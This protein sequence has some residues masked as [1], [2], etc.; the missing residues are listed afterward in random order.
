MA[1]AQ[2]KPLWRQ[3]WSQW[4][5]VGAIALMALLSSAPLGLA[6]TTFPPNPLEVQEDDPL[7]PRT[8]VDRPLSPQERRVLETA[9]EEL[10]LQAEANYQQGDIA[11]AFDIWIRELRLRRV[12][13]IEQEVPALSR[14]GEVAWRENQTTE[15]RI[16][17][18]RLMEIEQEVQAQQPPDYDLLLQIAQAYQKLRAR[19]S[20]VSLYDQILVQ[21][22]QNGNTTLERQTLTALGEL[23]LAWFDYPN[24]AEVYRQLLALARQ[25]G[26]RPGIIQNQRQLIYIYQ[27]NDQL[28]EAIATQQELIRLFEASQ[29]FTELPALKLA[30]ADNYMAIERPDLAAPTYQEA[31]AISRSVQY[32]G[33]ASNALQRLAELYRALERPDD[34]LVV[35]QLLVDV[36]QQSYNSYGLMNAYDWIGQIHRSRGA[37]NQ[38]V[39][40][41]RQGLQIARQ[42]NYKV[43]YFTEQI[44]AL[45]GS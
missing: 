19:E 44:Q 35:Y 40:A 27:E 7:L 20:A 2:L 17:T 10:R 39:V 8:V 11:G 12:L 16:I 26:D 13:G 21:A 23:H 1:H 14:V 38:A 3:T 41:F 24:A 34:A 29:E 33:Y 18:E 42:L 6:Q 28:E 25:A 37:T 31:F 22:R 15:T 43:D 45:S 32:Y 36:E 4:S 30:L 9:L 5:K